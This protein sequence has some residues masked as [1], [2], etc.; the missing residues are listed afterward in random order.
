MSQP[1]SERPNAPA[2]PIQRRAGR[3]VLWIS[4]AKVLFVLLGFAVQF[5]LPRVLAS[6][7]EF[8]L[9]SSAMTFTAILTN[10]M[11]SSMVQTTS[12]LVAEASGRPVARTIALR[13]AG[14]GAAIAIALAIGAELVGLHVLH[15]RAL[16]PLVRLSSVIVVAYAVYATAI[17]ALNGGQRFARQAQLDATFS[18]A[19]TLGLLGGGLALGVAGSAMG[20]FAAA[21]IAMAVVGTVVARLLEPT[22]G[23]L[24]PLDTH[25]RVLV[26]IALY[27]LFLNGLLQLDLEILMTGATFTAREAGT[28]LEEAAHFASEQAGLYRAAQTL[29]FVPYQL[30]T[31][32]TL[33]LFP[34][35]AR[36]ASLGDEEGV[37]SAVRGALRFSAILLAGLLAPLAGGA[38]GAVR[39]A[40]PAAYVEA[41][42]AVPALAAGQF[43]FAL[44]V[45]QATVLVSR[46][47]VWRTVLLVL[48]TATVG[49]VG[50]LLAWE[51]APN[52]LRVGTAVGT[53]V[54][55]LAMWAGTA[56]VLTRSTGMDETVARPALGIGARVAVAAALACAVARALPQTDRWAGLVAILGGGLAYVVALAITG[57]IGREELALVRRVLERGANK[58]A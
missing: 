24:A 4:G 1:P 11:T 45:V 20:G 35:V 15:Q 53:A 54:G 9:L 31:S 46:G 38:E 28:P 12:K 36:A 7:S 17:G 29:A 50:N 48:A 40:F 57:E 58:G 32:V 42:D 18:V 39:F 10:A 52:A 37:Q 26:P 27:Q 22:S 21:A 13:H 8:G 25:L 30:V 56:F 19:R 34:I 3:G 33:V 49:A 2:P 43:F 51:I 5:G 16:V 41:A 14:I 44:G 23:N 55:G 6:T 47:L